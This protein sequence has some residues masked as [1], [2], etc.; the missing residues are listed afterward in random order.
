MNIVYSTLVVTVWFMS[1]FFI[2]LMLLI[3]LN[4]KDKMHKYVSV[5][6]KLPFISVI[7]PAYNE[8]EGILPALES[9]TVLDYPRDLYEIIIIN[10]GST[11]KTRE[12]IQDFV[13]GHEQVS[14][15]FIDRCDNHGK[16]YSLNEGIRHARGELVACMDAD[17]IVK[18]DIFLKTVGYFSDPKTGSVSVKVNVRNASKLLEK[19]I[20]IEYAVGLSIS[21]KILSMLGAL[22]VTPGPFSMYRKTILDGIGGFDESNITEDLEIAF[23][24][25]KHGYKLFFCLSTSVSTIVPSDMKSL[26]KQRRRWYSGALMTVWQHKDVILKR[27]LGFFGLFIPYSY[28]LIF[29]G[30]IL[31]LYSIFLTIRRFA[32]GIQYWSLINFDLS[33]YEFVLNMDPLSIDIF[34]TLAV[35]MIIT[36]LILTKSS[37]NTIKRRVRDNVYGVIGFTFFFIFYQLFWINSLYNVITNREIKWR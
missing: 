32:L 19:I 10:D 16:S 22:H 29:L 12:Y 18:P 4:K 17:S 27:R 8:E 33:H 24:L 26:Y 37:I 15:R 3:L 25:Q 30:M 9:L 20:D 7:L 28:S 13:A 5:P 35:S 6:G 2:V 34:S 23:R 31:F 14:L 1:T 11:D 21:L 36:T